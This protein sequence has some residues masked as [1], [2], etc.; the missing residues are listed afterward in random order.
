MTKPGQTF[1]DARFAY[2]MM[3]AKNN[4]HDVDTPLKLF[5]HFVLYSGLFKGLHLVTSFDSGKSRCIVAGF[6]I[7]GDRVRF[8]SQTF[9]NHA[10]VVKGRI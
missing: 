2:A 1:E 8:V 5:V 10:D 6:L 9:Q 3:S 7:I 4:L